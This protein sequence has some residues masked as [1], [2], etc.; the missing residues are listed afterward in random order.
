MN[1]SG[2]G[3][4]RHDVGAE[5][6]GSAVDEFAVDLRDPKAVL[7]PCAIEEVAA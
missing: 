6:D 3:T 1:R 7:I 2:D 4:R 5:G